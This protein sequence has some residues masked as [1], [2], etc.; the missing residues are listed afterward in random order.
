MLMPYFARIACVCLASFWVIQMAAGLAVWLI[1]P[2]AI[3]TAQRIRPGHAAHLLLVLRLLPCWFG[4]LIVAALC[5]PSYL[6]LEP[7][8]TAEHV[9]LGFLAAAVLGLL[10]CSASI[11]RGLLAFIRSRRF[12]LNCR[13]HSRETELVTGFSRVWTIEGSMPFLALAGIFR[14]QLIVSRGTLAAL[15]PDLLQAALRHERAHCVSRDNLKHL[16]LL[17]A[18]DMLPF[19]GL[20]DLE[21]AWAKFTEW[22]ADDIAAA[23]NPVDS[24]ALAAALVRLARMGGTPSECALVTSLMP[25]RVDLAA[26]VNR[27][28]SESPQPKAAAPMLIGSGLGVLASLVVAVM[29][30]PATLRSAYRLLERLI[31]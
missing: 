28:L 18:P 21:R 17:L 9:R 25:S 19:F 24:T 10:V 6:Q 27:L 4:I 5:L 29:L 31:N 15:S 12:L 14:P 30:Q 20:R 16:L 13:R 11:T 23:G 2:V 7:D 8:A 3:R 22:A 26:R 1:T